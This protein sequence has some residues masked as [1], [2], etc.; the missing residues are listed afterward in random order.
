M[1]HWWM[2]WST[3]T[4]PPRAVIRP[5]LRARGAAGAAWLSYARRAG[6]AALYLH[7]SYLH[8]FLDISRRCPRWL[9]RAVRNRHRHAIEQISSDG[10]EVDWTP[11]QVHWIRPDPNRILGG[12]RRGTIRPEVL[13]A[14][15]DDSSL[16]AL[17]EVASNGSSGKR[18]RPSASKKAAQGRSC[19]ERANRIPCSTP[20]QQMR[21]DGPS[22]AIGAP[23]I[24]ELK[25]KDESLGAAAKDFRA[26]I[27]RKKAREEPTQCGK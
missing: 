4:R 22:R 12:R 11:Q 16:P 27:D 5:S 14:R 21:C 8:R 10:V 26:K 18:S 20:V 7:G 25:S 3:T 6:R 17:E 23:S 13:D 15:K 1:F 24:L 2:Q 9:R 19:Y